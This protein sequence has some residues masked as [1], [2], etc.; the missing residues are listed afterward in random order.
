[1]NYV[2]LILRYLSGELS[3]EEARDFKDELAS[4]EELKQEFAEVSAA[5]DLIRDQLQHRD[6]QAFRQKLHS[7]MDR[8]QAP[9][10][11][12][13]RIRP[14]RYVLVALAASLALLLMVK[15]PPR[16]NE[17]ILDRYY[18]PGKDPFLQTLALDTRGEQETGMLLFRNHRYGEAMDLLERM[19]LETPE[20]KSLLLYY[21]LSAMEVDREGEAMDRIQEL[22]LEADL[23]PD[24]A[25]A[26]YGSL[27]L[28]KSDRRTEALEMLEPLIEVP[29]PYTSRA[30]KLKKML[31]K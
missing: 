23:P 3:Q 4:N 27:A 16:S 15:L 1:M 26:W 28:I 30:E 18:T 13:Y 2:D 19:W 29:G 5:Y 10:S 17:R 6:E 8:G 20:N 7:A 12:R 21:L 11:P 14:V 24:R 22:T 9:S 31:L 25:I